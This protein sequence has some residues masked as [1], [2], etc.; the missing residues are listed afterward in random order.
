MWCRY[1]V[2]RDGPTNELRA[3]LHRYARECAAWVVSRHRE[4]LRNGGSV[5]IT[6]DPSDEPSWLP[7]AA[8]V[9]DGRPGWLVAISEGEHHRVYR[10]TRVT[11][12]TRLRVVH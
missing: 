6:V 5:Y 11:R 12:S 9:L 3:L 8:E 4:K 10:F 2:A 1:R 7:L